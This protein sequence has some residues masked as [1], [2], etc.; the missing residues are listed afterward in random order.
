MHARLHPG[1]VP[2]LM[3]CSVCSG[4]RR[5]HGCHR[6]HTQPRVDRR[7]LCWCGPPLC[8]SGA[9]RTCTAPTQSGGFMTNGNAI[10]GYFGA[11]ATDS[12]VR[13]FFMSGASAAQVALATGAQLQ[14]IASTSVRL[15]GV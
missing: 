2:S 5:H 6:N 10:M 11:N 12:G 15:A 1:P 14:N 8:G 4:Q 7:V 13:D 3:L 9:N